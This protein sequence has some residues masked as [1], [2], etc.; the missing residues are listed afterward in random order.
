MFDYDVD[1]QFLGK[2]LVVLGIGMG[3]GWLTKD[4]ILERLMSRRAKKTNW[5]RDKNEIQGSIAVL[6]NTLEITGK[7]SAGGIDRY[8]N[9]M[10]KRGYKDLD[11]EPKFTE[12]KPFYSG[13]AKFPNVLKLKSQIKGRLGRGWR[14]ALVALKLK[15]KEA[16]TTKDPFAHIAR[17]RKTT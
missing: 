8:R 2:S 5:K 16:P 13:P 15:K 1:L 14:A 10:R 11:L 3:L 12:G 9:D 6:L 4:M 7:V 17:F